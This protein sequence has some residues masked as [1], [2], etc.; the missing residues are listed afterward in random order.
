MA[1]TVVNM[2]LGGLSLDH[3]VCGILSQEGKKVFS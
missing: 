2:F 3:V 1:M